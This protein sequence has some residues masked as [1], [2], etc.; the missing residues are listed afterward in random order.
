MTHPICVIAEAGVNH[1]GDLAC[2]LEMVSVAA[3][4]GADYIKF[5][6]FTAD[7]LV[8]TCAPTA[9]YQAAN[10]G[11]RDQ[12]SLLRDLEIGPDGFAELA[13]ACRSN[14]IGFMATAFDTE[15]VDAL[16]ALGM[17]RIKIASG[18]LTNGPALTGFAALG[19]PILLSTGMATLTEVERAVGLLQAG[20]AESITLLQCTSLYPAPAETLNLRAMNTMAEQFD[21]PVGFSDHSLG[22]HASVAAAALGASV[23]E[24]HFTLDR[25]LEGPDHAASLEPGELGQLIAMLRD[26]PSMLGDG[27]KAPA[28][29]EADTAAVV[30]RSWH[31][32][33]DLAAG[34]VV[35]VADVVLKRPANGLDGWESPAGRRLVRAVAANSPLMAADL[36]DSTDQAMV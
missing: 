26:L 34:E 6:A 15:Q 13:E 9:A 17:D 29:A 5:Q 14:G 30:R 19:L 33:R 23:I 36:A 21:L 10:T 7:Q 24:K 12:A 1:N 28:A 8:A 3:D 22:L 27:V 32:S 2:A 31:A 20:G 11:S 16:I 4:A 18:E 35:E 25:T